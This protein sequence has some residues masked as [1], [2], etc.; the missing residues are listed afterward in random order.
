MINDYIKLLGQR[1]YFGI[2]KSNL[3]IQ[4]QKSAEFPS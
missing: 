3:N 2:D 4:V 1:N